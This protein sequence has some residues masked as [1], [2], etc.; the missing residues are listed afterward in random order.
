LKPERGG[1]DPAKEEI[2]VDQSRARDELLSSLAA[3]EDE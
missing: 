3:E 2:S 1:S